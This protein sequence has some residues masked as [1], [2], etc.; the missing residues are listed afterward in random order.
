MRSRLNLEQF[1]VYLSQPLDPGTVFRDIG[2]INQVFF[3][4][5]P[6]KSRLFPFWLLGL[7]FLECLGD[8]PEE[9]IS[10]EFPT[11]GTIYSSVTL[12]SDGTAFIGSGDNKVYA[13][14]TDGT[15]KWE[16]ETGDWVDTVPALSPDESAVYVGSWDNK[17]Y[18]I[19]AVT[20]AL[21]WSYETGNYLLASPAVGADGVIYFGSNDN[22]F[23]AL[24][25]D[26]TLKWEYFLE[27]DDT[28][29]IHSSAA[30]GE[31]GTIYFG[32]H[33]GKLY[34]LN[35]DGSFLWS[36][37]VAAGLNG[38]NSIISSPALDED[39]NIYFGAG[40]GAFYSLDSSGQLRWTY[41]LLEESEDDEPLDSSPVVGPL[42]N[43][44]FA[45]REGYLVSLDNEG[46][47]LWS[48]DVGDV[49]LSAP[50]VDSEGNVYIPSYFGLAEDSE[51]GESQDVSGITAFDSSGTELWDYSLTY[52]YIDSSPTMDANGILY[53]GASDGSVVAL[54]TGTTNSLA[55]GAWPKLRNDLAGTGR[56]SSLF[57]QLETMD[58]GNGWY[59][60]SW[61]GP[62]YP[63]GNGWLYHLDLGWVS[64]SGGDSSSWLWLPDT[65]GW[66]WTSQ[67]TYPFLYRQASG[68][69][70]Y[71]SARHDAFY[72]YGESVGWFVSP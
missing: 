56:S 20:G 66:Y 48:M 29:L 50:L 59:H 47:E 4:Y 60:G 1:F 27:S 9:P 13:L 54:N 30:I 21:S 3:P 19:N 16:Y 26:G 25:P 14:N 22:F 23:Y 71:Y 2:G 10:W 12:A 7:S 11:G 32:A 67:S 17:L 40:S 64:L 43:I 28:V 57:Y 63:L 72:H 53:I 61:L 55:D 68:Y 62:F 42:G 38:E 34:A 5:M 39:G 70:V 8:L 52:G 45:T 31:D 35:P 18:A 41:R 6:L 36:Y 69:W 33:D 15:L 65:S 51:T 44:Y 37:Q 24:S 46:V 49:F 58:L